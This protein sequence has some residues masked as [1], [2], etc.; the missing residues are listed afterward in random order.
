MIVRALALDKIN[1]GQAWSILFRQ[2]WIGF[3]QGGIIGI[4]VG[5][6]VGIWQNNPFLGLV[7][8]LALVGNLIIAAIVGTLI[9]LLLKYLNQDP[10]LASSVLV[11][12]A[13]DAIG[14]LI[15]L[16][17][18]SIFLPYIQQYINF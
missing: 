4:M 7:L 6:S 15:Y 12:S 18:A 17:L 9:P 1:T 2:I 14:F 16:S 10:A 5:F 13:T 3:L 8:G 11:T